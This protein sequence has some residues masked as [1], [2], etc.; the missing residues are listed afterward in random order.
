MTELPLFSGSVHE[1]P[2]RPK[3][4]RNL[5]DYGPVAAIARSRYFP[6]VFQW[7]TASVFFVIVWQL[8]LG[9]QTAHD[10]AGTALVWVL[11]WPLLPLLFLALGRFWCA[12]CPFG[13]LSDQVQKLVGVH[14]R[15]PK[16]LKSYGIWVIDALFILITWGDHVFGIVESPWGSGVLLLMLTTGVIVSGALYER[17]T[18]CRYVCFLGGVAGNYSRSGMVQLRANQ[19]ICS[20]CK[21]KAVCFNGSANAPACPLFEFPRQMEESANCVLCASC[22]KNCPNGAIE[23]TVRPPTKELWFIRKPRL[24]AAF[25]AVAIMGIVFIQNITMLGFWADVEAAIAGVVG[26]DA[27]AVVYTI[28]FAAAIASTVGLLYVASVIAG[29]VNGARAWRNFARFGYALIPLDVAGHVAHNLFH[30]LAEGKNIVT[31]TVALVGVRTGGGSAA[32]ASTGTIQALQYAILALGLAGSLYT[33]WRIADRRKITGRRPWAQFA[34]Y[35][36]LI[37]LFFAVNVVL[38][39]LPMAH[40]M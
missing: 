17:R 8:L 4:P 23:V 15:V 2:R 12:V 34:P 32:V 37:A 14:K 24:E 7:M 21:S 29:R 26:T 19:D 40:R 33:A 27:K 5:L 28:V 10:N 6:V 11:W 18:F 13:W 36:L 25:L 16:F 22:I 1:P 38:F 20:S 30:L 3:R 31:T 39:A 9:P 35:A